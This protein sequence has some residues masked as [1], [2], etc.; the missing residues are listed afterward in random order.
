ML[1]LTLGL[2]GV[3][4]LQ[5]APAPRP[6]TLAARVVML[7]TGT[8]NADPERSGPAVA[9]LVGGRSYIVDAGPGVVRRAAAAA[10]LGHGALAPERLTTVFLTHLH[11]DH[12][13]GLPDLIFSPWTLERTVPL[14]VI[15][16]PGTLAMTSHIS[17]AWSEDLTV[18]LDG[19]EPANTTGYRVDAREVVPGVVYQDELVTVHAFRVPHGSWPHSYGYRF[20]TRDKVIV[21]SGDTGPT[22]VTAEQCR[23]CDV[24]V[25]E[26]Y[27][28][29]RFVTRPPE[30]QRYHSGFHV[31]TVEVARIAHLARPRL[32]V[33]YHQ[34]YWGTTDAA[35]EA[36]VRAAGYQGR[37]VSARDL[38]E[39]P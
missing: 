30:W 8:P 37:V 36:E 20:V 28:T 39:Y 26:V 11:S 14:T 1:S 19:L 21:I 13:L 25:H 18:R 29:E 9:V 6:D 7:G 27:S 34:L 17:A 3:A 12:T 4:V 23:G 10:R 32:L 22:D 31:S 5:A 35:L 16:P 15:G 2:L 38:G 33:L 24:L